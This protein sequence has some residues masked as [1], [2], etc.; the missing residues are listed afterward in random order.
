MASSLGCLPGPSLCIDDLSQWA[1]RSPLATLTFAAVGE[2]AHVRSTINSPRTQ[3][4]TEPLFSGWRTR[5]AAH[6]SSS[7]MFDFVAENPH[8]VEWALKSPTTMTEE[9]KHLLMHLSTSPNL[10]LKSARRQIHPDH[11]SPIWQQCSR[12]LPLISRGVASLS[13]ARSSYRRSPNE[14]PYSTW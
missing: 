11:N 7:A 13:S 8:N 10:I 2:V 4:L 1:P 14:C 6:L 5:N 12:P 9:G 3:V